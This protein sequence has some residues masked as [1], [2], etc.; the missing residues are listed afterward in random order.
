MPM[1]EMLDPTSRITTLCRERGIVVG[2]MTD[3]RFSGGSVGLVIGH[4]VQVKRDA[5]D[6][7]QTAFLQPAA[8]LERLEYVLVILD[9]E[10]GLPPIDEQPIACP[11]DG[12]LPEGESPCFASPRPSTKPASPKP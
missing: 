7:V 8:H 6:V 12:T 11:S 1:R 4:V 3:A 9:Y 5:N 2:L 10:G